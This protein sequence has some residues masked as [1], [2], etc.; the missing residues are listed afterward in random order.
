LRWG[1]VNYLPGL[2][3]TPVLQSSAFQAARII[4]MGHWHQAKEL[5]F[6]I[7]TKICRQMFIVA[8]F[9]IAKT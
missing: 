9:V 7:H 4:G 3:S 6:Y 2:A 5:K 1:L 8:S